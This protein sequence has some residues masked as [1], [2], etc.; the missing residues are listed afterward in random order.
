MGSLWELYGISIAF[1]NQSVDR[2]LSTHLITRYHSLDP[3]TNRKN[4]HPHEI[5]L[6]N[7]E[8]AV[9]SDSETKARQLL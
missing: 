4:E 5:S 8:K 7:G 2:S 9:Y 3:T 1:L 6:E